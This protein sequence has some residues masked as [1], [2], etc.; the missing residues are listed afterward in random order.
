MTLYL[1]WYFS[2]VRGKTLGKSPLD[3]NLTKWLSRCKGSFHKG[4]DQETRHGEN[5]CKTQ[6]IKTKPKAIQ[7]RKQRQWT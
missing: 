2:N 4:K 7:W 5:E 6:L 3:I 1:D